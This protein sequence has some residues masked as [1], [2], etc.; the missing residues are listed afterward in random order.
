MGGQTAVSTTGSPLLY[1][2]RHGQST[3][4][5]ER[6]IQGQTRSPPLT[7]LGR[8]QARRAAMQLAQTG[9]TTLLTSDAMRAMQTAKIIGPVLGLSSTPTSLL[10]EQHWG[11]LQ[12]QSSEKAWAV[13]ARLRDDERFPGGEARCDVR[14]RLEQLL[15]SDVLRDAAGPV[16]LVSHG[17]TIAQA[18]RFL[19]GDETAVPTPDNG[20]VICVGNRGKNHKRAWPLPVTGHVVKE[21]R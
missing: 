5:V 19:S 12:G 3:W 10:R 18:V 21:C 6:R 15:Q 7:E 16:V 13:G 17:D 14:A 8:H 1:F 20:T 2:V 9:A 4:N 11:D